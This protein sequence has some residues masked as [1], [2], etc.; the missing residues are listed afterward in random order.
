M[1]CAYVY[2]RIA[3]GQGSRAADTIAALLSM[4]TVHCA[5]P[6]C[7]LVRCDDASTWM[8][9]YEVAGD[10]AAFE[11]ALHAAVRA[12][13]CMDFIQGQRHLECF[14][15]GAPEPPPAG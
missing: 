10:F 13:D 4:M 7:R 1:K 2:Y 8:E 15:P 11:T 12:L 6:P 5:A 9:R 14:M 3:P